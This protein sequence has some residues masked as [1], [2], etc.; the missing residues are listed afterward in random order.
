MGR[1]ELVR[2]IRAHGLRYMTG[3]TFASITAF[4]VLRGLKTPELRVLQHAK[5][6]AAIA[7][8]S[9]AVFSRAKLSHD[10]ASGGS[11]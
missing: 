4:L 9:H 8:C 3:A 2:E 10:R 6:A 1:E 11:L 7:D 5:S